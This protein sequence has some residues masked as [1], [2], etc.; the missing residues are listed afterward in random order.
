[1]RRSTLTAA[2]L[3]T[4]CALA[5]AACGSKSANSPS[6][7]STATVALQNNAHLTQAQLVVR[8]KTALGGVAAVHINGGTSPGGTI[9]MQI[10]KDDT[11]RGTIDADGMSMPVIQLG[12]ITYLQITRS[13]ANTVKSELGAI[14]DNA[15][16]AQYRS[17][18]VVGKWLKT[19]TYGPGGDGG[20]SGTRIVSQLTT[21]LT[22]GSNTFTYLGTSTVE[23]QPVAQYKDVTKD[24]S[25]PTA[26]MS[27]ALTGRALPI[28]DDAGTHGSTTF[29]WNQ[30]TT[31]TAPP[32]ADVVT[33][34]DSLT[35]LPDSSSTGT[36]SRTAA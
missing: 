2:A 36:P 31:I 10:N 20:I 24:G 7:A 18:I 32:A 34:P 26:T 5:L 23:G 4:A 19:A 35:G 11:D 28:L 9:D 15:L 29:T 3:V 21:Q 25:S 14:G 16:V 12:S 6:P 22:N 33:L 1:M 30:P 17:E 8:L 13:Y 27:V